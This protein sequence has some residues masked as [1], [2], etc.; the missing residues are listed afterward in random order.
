MKVLH[1]FTAVDMRSG[2]DG[3]VQYAKSKGIKLSEIGTETACIFISRDRT[4]MKAYSY[5][6]VVS[7]MK[8]PDRTRPFDLS[9]IDEFPRAF[10]K[11]G[12]MDYAKALKAKL[13]KV[14][15]TKGMLEEEML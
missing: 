2:H 7:Y 10:N 12:T 6:G 3:L 14:M 5:N 8:A 11:N 9:A 1:V 15:A 13:T 4:R